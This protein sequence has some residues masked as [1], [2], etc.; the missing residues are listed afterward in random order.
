MN[1]YIPFILTALVSFILTPLVINFAKKYKLLD[2]PQIRFHPASIHQ[3]VVPRAG[4][5]ALFLAL[6]ISIFLFIGLS[7]FTICLFLSSLILTIVGLLDDRRDINPYIRFSINCFVALIMILFA[8]INIP[9]ITNPLTGGIINLNQWQISLNMPLVI[10]TYF[11]A[12]FLAFLWILWTMHI[13]GWSAGVDGQMPGF[14]IISAITIGLLSLRFTILD[15]TQEVVTILAFIVAGAFLGFLPWNFYPQKIMPG[16]SGKILA[17]FFLALLGILAYAKVGTALL[18]LG[19]PMIDAV[20]T[21]IRRLSS[22]KP[23][24]AADKGHLHHRLLQIGWGKRRVA[25]FYWL[26]S[27]ILGL[28]ALFVTSKQ[29]VFTLLL[30]AVGFGGL[31]LWLNYF[32]QF[33]KRS[34]RDSG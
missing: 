30:I 4:G 21:L 34:D 9:Y 14:V 23:L 19:V 13:V 20:F 2:D 25:L 12:D 1:F 29:K 26:I 10:K 32:S 8:K 11:V 28:V 31:V 5:L 33:S 7:N 18:V 22:H 3:G 24:V 27:A 6:S 16:Y 17:G 15:P